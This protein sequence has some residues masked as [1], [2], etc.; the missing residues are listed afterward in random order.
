MRHSTACNSASERLVRRWYEAGRP[1]AWLLPLSWLFGVVVRLRR[2]AF[3]VGLARV[4]RS[5]RPVIVIGNLTVG[6]SGKTPLVIWLAQQL[7]QRGLR[8]AVIS[9]GYGRSVKGAR[10]LGP[11]DTAQTVGDEPL[12]VA[13]RTGMPVAVGERRIDAARLVEGDCD[14]ILSD[15]GLQHYNLHRDA[16][17]VVMDGRRGLGNAH[18]LPAGPLREPPERLA[19]VD[20]LVCT[21]TL[22]PASGGVLMTLQSMRWVP[23]AGGE[24]QPPSAM[25]GRRAHVLA[26]IGN[27]ERFFEHLRSLGVEVIPLPLR[28]HGVPTAG[29]VDFADEL[30]ILMTEKDAVKYP[31]PVDGRHWYL[32]VQ[33]VIDPVGTERLLGGVDRVLETVSAGR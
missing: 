32:E 11:E 28:D 31:H 17:I 5:L 3:R 23:L 30:P 18:L 12:L 26:G 1:S 16:E 27:P 24:A 6:G 13:R 15:D 4:E 9:R 21:G 8:P 25:A 2:L 19:E 10:R 33:A 14:L 22:P 7:Q 20:A 29:E